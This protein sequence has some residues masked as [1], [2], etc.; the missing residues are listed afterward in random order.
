MTKKPSESFREYA[1]RWRQTASQ[2]QSALTEK[3]NVTI[4]I[5]TMLSS[6]YYDMLIGHAERH[7]PICSRLENGSR[8][9]SK[10]ER[11]RITKHSLSSSLTKQDS[12][13]KNLFAPRTENSKQRKGGHTI[14]SHAPRHQQPSVYPTPVYHISAL[15]PPYHVIYHPQLVYYPSNRAHLIDYTISVNRI[16]NKA[17]LNGIQTKLLETSSFCLNHCQKYIRSC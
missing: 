11:S 15:P 13:K 2:V 16:A 3:E 10:S 17:T 12:M 9:G 1:Q 7:L 6:T 14:S 5:N 4:F 8:M